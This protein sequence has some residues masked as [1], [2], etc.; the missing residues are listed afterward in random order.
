MNFSKKNHELR[1]TNKIDVS[2]T[3]KSITAALL[4]LLVISATAQQG[5]NY[6]ALIKDAGGNVVANQSITV[7]FQILQGPGMTNVY[8]ETHTPTTDA[9]GI[10][11]VNIGEGA[12]DSGVFVDIDWGSD[13]HYL[14]VQIDTGSGLVDMGTTQFTAVPYA[15]SVSKE[16]VKI[17]DL[18]D[19]KS[20]SDGSQDGSS[21]FLGVN[22]GQNDDSTDNRNVGIGLDALK[23]NTS[24]IENT[25]NGYSALISNTTGN[26]NTANGYQALLFNVIG[27]NNTAFG[28]YALN[29]TIGSN[30]TAIGRNAGFNNSTGDTNIFIGY[31]SGFNETGSNTLYIENTNANADN[32]L[33]YGEFGNNILRTNSEFQIGN[34]T[35]TGF[36]FPT[37]D[38]TGSQILQTDGNGSLGWS[39]IADIT[40]QSIND[41]TDGKS[42][43]DGSED[44]SSVFL[45]VNAGANDDVTDNRNVGIGFETLNNNTIGNLNSAS[46]YHALYSNSTGD[47]N[48]A[49]GAFTLAN[50]SIGAS[51]TAVGTWA[52]FNNTDGGSNTANGALA[53]FLNTTGSE[54]T[55]IGFNAMH[56][57][58]TGSSNTANGFFAL[59][60]NTTGSNNTA[61]GLGALQ[62]NTTG[63]DNTANGSQSLLGSTIGSQNT[64]NGNRALYSNTEGNSNA[65]N[66]D[67]T[68]LSN[69]TG[70]FNSAN[71]AQALLNNTTGSN[72]TANGYQSLQANTT[73]SNNTALG[74]NAQVPDGTLDNQ[75]RIGDTNVTLIEGQVAWSF[76]S[77]KRWKDK[78]REL[79]YGLDLVMQLNS[80]DY[81]RK[82][83]DNKTREMGFIAQDVEALLTKI[84]YTDQG[85]LHKD[86]KGFMSLRYND[87]IAL[88]TK[89]IQEQQEIIDDLKKENK[90]QNIKIESQSTD[91]KSLLSR[92]QKIENATRIN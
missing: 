43:S 88:L 40:V 39:S 30:N 24:G 65:A 37:T 50:N 61:T 76:T 3:L 14:N 34:P 80:V 41:L 57:N 55:A 21:L 45:G 26:Q 12:V 71:G 83:N 17:N 19:A 38:G 69:T 66:G 9:N 15:M 31:Q 6:K 48:V 72:N 90:Q 56:D 5:I 79:P 64:A 60:D 32:A 27:N 51:N 74:Y 25:S 58:T 52:L 85:F 84:G 73:G 75:V 82:N 23:S 54:N 63:I 70:D 62:L 16:T 22:A 81:I 8:Q 10:A 11:I 13:E 91:I 36:A 18:T 35:G 68:L 2:K 1:K 49:I 33:I 67:Q 4:M 47:F 7:Q 42:D 77:D 28:S 78:I 89:A 92:M 44:G 86:D 20:D 87:F 53:L 59:H 29:K 46:G